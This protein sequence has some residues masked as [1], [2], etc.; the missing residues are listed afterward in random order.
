MDDFC[1]AWEGGGTDDGRG[2]GV[3]QTADVGSDD[4][5]HRGGTHHP[6]Q[7]PHVLR[8]DA[9]F[10]GRARSHR[11]HREFWSGTPVRPHSTSLTS[12][13]E[14]MMTHS[15]HASIACVGRYRRDEGERLHRPI[16][17]LRRV[18]ELHVY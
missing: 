4:R 2:F 16:P 15:I 5:A 1:R 13:E 11:Q 18:P 9:L 12:H 8:V 17:L 10:I 6:D 7:R 14:T 3:R